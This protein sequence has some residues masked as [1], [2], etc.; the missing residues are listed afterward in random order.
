GQPGAGLV[1]AG[2]RIRPRQVGRH[3]PGRGVVGG[4][5]RE[6]AVL[7]LVVAEREERVVR[8]GVEQRRRRAGGGPGGLDVAGGEDVLGRRLGRRRSRRRPGR[9]WR[10]RD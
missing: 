5:L 7:V 9:R 2:R 3:A 6:R 4:V 8:G 10:R 1:V